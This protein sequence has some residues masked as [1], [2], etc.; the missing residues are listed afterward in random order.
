MSMAAQVVGGGLS[1]FD[2][3][4]SNEYMRKGQSNANIANMIQQGGANQQNWWQLLAQN[5]FNQDQWNKTAAWNERMWDA[6]NKFNIEQRDYMNQYNSPESQMAR[7]KAAGLNPHLIYGSGSGSTGNQSGGVSASPLNMAPLRSGKADIGRAEIRN[8]Q[9]GRRT[10]GIFNDFAQRM[11]TIDNVE[12]NTQVLKQEAVAKSYQTMLTAAKIAE[13]GVSTERKGFDLGLA[14]ELRDTSMTAAKAN[15]DYAVQRARQMGA[16]AQVAVDTS[17][18]RIQK[19]QVEVK[20]L[21]QKVA[22]A[23]ADQKIKLLLEGIKEAELRLN[24]QGIQ[25]GDNVIFRLLM[26]NETIR[27]LMEHINSIEPIDFMHR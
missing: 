27:Q 13:T 7:L 3:L 11:A 9:A 2:T 19:A 4:M 10:F 21:A 5:K 22:N 15:A 26:Q 23:K 1:I 14:K 8:E 6:N 20:L 17:D 24:K 25:K 12:A 16:N 18:P